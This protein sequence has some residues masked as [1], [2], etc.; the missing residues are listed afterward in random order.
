MTGG[1]REDN[2]KIISKPLYEIS[3]K[4]SLLKMSVDKALYL[5]FQLVYE[6]EE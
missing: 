2:L 6:I 1:R 5:F 4:T 3:I